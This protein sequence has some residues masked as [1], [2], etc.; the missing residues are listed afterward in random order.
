MLHKIKA[1]FLCA[2]K[3]AEACIDWKGFFLIIFSIFSNMAFSTGYNFRT[4]SSE[5]G[6]PQSYIYTINQDNHGYLW[7]GTGDGLSRYNGFVFENFTTIDSLAD[8]FIT[9][10]INDGKNQWFGHING[11]ISCFDGKMFRK[12]N[13]LESDQSPITHFAKSPDGQVWASTYADG[14]LKLNKEKGILKHYTFKNPSLIVSFEFIDNNTLLIGTNAGLL[15]CKLKESG[16]IEI[17]N[18]VSEIPESK[19]VCIQKMRNKSG[20]YIATEN[21]GIFQLFNTGKNIK[22]SK[23]NQDKDFNATG[24]QYIYEDTHSNLWLAT[25]GNGLI[26][27]N[28]SATGKITK[29]DYFNKANGFITDN[30]KHIF[31]DREGEI[32]SG[33]YGE[34]LTQITTKTFSIH[35]FDKA[36]H[37]NEIYSIYIDQQYRW[38]GTENGLLKIDLVTDKILKFYSKELPKDKFTSIFSKDGKELWIGTEKNGVFRMM[39]N[40]DRIVKFP[41]GD[42]ELENSIT[43]ITAK[44]EQ[45]WIGTKKGLCNIN[46]VHNDKKW[47]TINQGGLPHNFINCLHI[48]KKDRLWVSTQGNT[49]AYIQDG[50]VVKI[51]LNSVIRNRAMGP[52]TE[53]SE[54][55]I[56]M[57]SNGQGVFMIKSDSI[58]NFTL[59]DGLLS[60]YCYSI[61]C[62]NYKNIWV[63]HKGGLSKIKIS[64]FSVKPIQQF[65][66]R[67]DNYQ[68]NPNAIFKDQ[69]DKIWFGSNKGIVCYDPSKEYSQLKAPALSITSIKVNEEEKDYTDKIILSPG[70]YKIKIN[71]LGISLKESALVTYRYKLDGYDQWSENTKNNSITFNHL[72]DGEYTFI[73]KAYS[74]DGIVSDPLIVSITIKKPIWKKWWFYMLSFLSLIILIYIYIKRREKILIEEKRILEEKVKERTQEIQSQK[75]EIEIQN[76]IIDKKNANITASITYASKI[77]NAIFPPIEY[78]DKLLPDNFI[79]NKPKD[80][81]SG[82]FYWLAEKNNKIVFAIGDCTGHGVPGAFM[83]ILGVT[84][85]N[86][87][88]SQGFTNSDIIVTKLRENIISSLQQGRKGLTTRDGMDISLCVL[89]RQEKKIQFTGG[90]NNLV[91]V[92]NQKLDVVKADRISVC[93]NYGNSQSFTMKEFTYNKGDVLYLFS[94]GYK[95]Q[96]GGLKN[97]KYLIQHL[98]NFLLNIHEFSMKEQKELLLNEING[99]MG[100]STQ[101]DDITIM[102]IRL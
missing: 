17:I 5:D 67:N 26:K 18:Q 81:V 24:I 43:C 78:I 76:E 59:K 2:E 12:V 9:T 23:L 84:L 37:G 42:G 16:E 89:D 34:G 44:G 83:S 55:G 65:E 13:L 100:N 31:E 74:G 87:I 38:I 88:V 73:V 94:D 21:E 71:F 7:I 91:Y 64:D 28:Y 20:F 77:Q 57:G 98:Y 3:F 97:K 48:D 56:W 36:I 33:N 32:W 41:I 25:F 82:D 95:D 62:D 10:G 79:L 14:L 61:I 47:Y 54:S 99:W 70:I 85:L 8:N 4:F 46:L 96:F 30:V 69:Y 50:K 19:I 75:N 60:D 86:D 27:M 90:M 93:S 35:A 40:T 72:I 22:V 11:G 49:P 68:F 52:I 6:L 39:V 58:V 63:G 15:Y 92:H 66:D 101:T 45:V 80:I 1:V 53:D 29:I 102:G 51:P